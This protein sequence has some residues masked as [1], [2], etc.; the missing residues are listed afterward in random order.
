MKYS[1]GFIHPQKTTG[2]YDSKSHELLV[3]AGFIDQVGSGIFTLLT[4]GKLVMNKIENAIRRH[5]NELDAHE[6][7]M[8]CL[9]PKANWEKTSRWDSFDVLFKVKSQT[10]VEYGLGPSHEEIVTPLAQKMIES[11]RDL[12]FSVYQIATKFR[13]EVRAKSGILRGRE[14]GMKDMYS[15][16]TDANDFEAFYK[17][18]ID[19]YRELFTE[20]GLA[21]VKITEA[22]GGAF[23]KKNSH[24]F[25]VITDAGEVDLVYCESCDF[26]QNEEIFKGKD[27][28]CIH[29]GKKL[30][31][32]KAIEVGNIFDLG[33]KFSHDFDLTYTDIAGKKKPVHMGCYGIG[34]TRLLGTI[35]ETHYD[36]FGIVWP[37]NLTPFHVH[38][39]NLSKDPGRA[40]L[41][42]R[43]LE[44]AGFDVLYDDRADV[45]AGEKFAI[46]DLMGIPVRLVV[47][48]R[49]GD[50]IELKLRS[51]DDKAIVPYQKVVD[52]LKNLYNF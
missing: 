40:D 48:D 30:L 5:M 1:K 25:N 11:Y 3:R 16:H 13:D 15:F 2:Q 32:S 10:D 45:S 52:I 51:E 46:A 42:H 6:I 8:P 39:V 29:C 33:E 9:Q 14:F 12:P 27:D 35:V 47:S 50:D 26:V 36:D 17:K 44:S 20:L 21:D 37:I 19:K 7:W 43:S 41:V 24:E 28:V 18:V 31:H 49:T 34:T 38:L 22:A 4:P 23:S